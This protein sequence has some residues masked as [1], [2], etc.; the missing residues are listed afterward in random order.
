MNVFFV[1]LV[2]VLMLLILTDVKSRVDEV[3]RDITNEI[4][5][6]EEIAN[7]LMRTDNELD[8]IRIDIENMQKLY[9][10]EIRQQ[11]KKE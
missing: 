2:T 9:L 8:G 6:L 3:K 5:V 11:T 1:V 10:S 7:V 4:D